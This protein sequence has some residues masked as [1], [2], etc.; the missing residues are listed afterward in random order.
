MEQQRDL[1]APK[2]STEDEARLWRAISETIHKKHNDDNV[3]ALI[4]FQANERKKK[5]WPKEITAPPTAGPRIP[6]PPKVKDK[7]LMR[8]AGDYRQTEKPDWYLYG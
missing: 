8:A 2:Q 1:Y 4:T 5:K 6:T 7:S 3:R